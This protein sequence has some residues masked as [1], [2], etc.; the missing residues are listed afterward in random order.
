M[1]LA[2]CSRI[3]CWRLLLVLTSVLLPPAAQAGEY[4]YRDLFVG[5]RA[6][7]LGGAMVG[8]ADDATAA[9]YNPAGLAHAD[10]ENISL[11]A[12]ALLY[13]QL[14][15]HDYLGEDVELTSTASLPVASAVTSP[16][17][18]GRLAFTGVIPSADSFRVYRSLDSPGPTSGL[19]AARIDRERYDETYLAGIA[20]GQQIAE[21]LDIGLAAYY[22]FRRFRDLD[23]EFRLATMAD[24]N[25]MIAYRRFSDR[26][27]I[28]HGAMLALSLL[29]HPFVPEGRLR[30]GITL[31]TGAN[32]SDSSSAVE[33]RFLGFADPTPDDPDRIRYERQPVETSQG[34]VSRLPPSLEIGASFRILEN[35]LVAADLVLHSFAEYQSFGRRV[36]KNAVLNASVGTEFT[37]LDGITLRAGLF[38][39]RSAASQSIAFGENLQPDGYDQYGGTAGVTW[40]R[41]K[42]SFIVAVR[43]GRM[44][45]TAS[46]PSQLGVA[47]QTVKV[48]GAELG[49]TFGG[50][51][52]F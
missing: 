41:E 30:A 39:N 27:G 6:T 14:T 51:Y 8:L 34:G 3:P 5:A 35:W 43:A 11:N 37:P 40:N 32:I 47:R 25:G 52:F 31:R 17:F 29:Y 49:L 21:E 20:Y 2:I 10:H 36:E 16:F 24:E 33:E 48:G 7:G 28:S 15:L 26:S 4:H 12:T 42:T 1:A 50:A 9:W 38:S 13:K 19:E 18:R 45:G 46:V 44:S 23:G 22:V